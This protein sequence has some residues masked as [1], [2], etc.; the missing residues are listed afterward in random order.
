MRCSLAAAWEMPQLQAAS[1][2]FLHPNLQNRA[3]RVQTREGDATLPANTTAPQG[4]AEEDDAG[5][6][7]E[8]GGT[9]FD[10]RAQHHCTRGP[11]ELRTRV[12][13]S[14]KTAKGE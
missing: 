6:D 8:P 7:A 4:L 5:G 11:T 14:V 3:S 2:I 10:P 13:N 12:H 1:S 9:D